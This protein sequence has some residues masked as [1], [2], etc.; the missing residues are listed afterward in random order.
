MGEAAIDPSQ[1]ADH[2]KCRLGKWY[3]GEGMQICGNMPSF[4]ALEEVHARIHALGRRQ[5]LHT[6]KV[7]R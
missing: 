6:M 7:I 2:H 4:K 1:L 5:Y 3:Y